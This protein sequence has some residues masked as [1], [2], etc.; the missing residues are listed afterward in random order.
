MTGLLNNNNQVK[1][2]RYFCPSLTVHRKLVFS[3]MWNTQWNQ[4]K[5][6]N[7][8]SGGEC[9]KGNEDNKKYVFIYIK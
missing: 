5:S 3:R 9:Q 6:E 1:K 8:G 4:D 2:K 7:T